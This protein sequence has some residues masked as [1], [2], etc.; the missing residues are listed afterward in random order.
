MSA[1]HYIGR[2]DRLEDAFMINAHQEQALILTLLQGRHPSLY[3]RIYGQRHVRDVW[4][5]E[6]RGVSGKNMVMPFN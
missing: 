5:P 2:N 4:Q 6:T 3:E 1:L